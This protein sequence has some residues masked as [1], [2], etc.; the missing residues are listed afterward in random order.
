M[1]VKL[2]LDPGALRR[3]R[4]NMDAAFNAD[5]NNCGG[6]GAMADRDRIADGARAIGILRRARELVRT[7]AC[8]LAARVRHLYAAHDKNREHAYQRKPQT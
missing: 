8:V 6:C 7:G 1:E 2:G 3:D 5:R 4:R